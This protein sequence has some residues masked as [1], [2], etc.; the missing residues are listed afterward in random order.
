[1]LSGSAHAPF[2]VSGGCPRS[3]DATRESRLQ[4][5]RDLPKNEKCEPRRRPWQSSFD[6]KTRITSPNLR[7]KSPSPL[8]RLILT[9]V[10]LSGDLI[11]TALRSDQYTM[12]ISM[13]RPPS[14]TNG[15]RPP[16]GAPS[17]DDGANARRPHSASTS[18]K[19]H[20]CCW[21][22]RRLISCA[23]AARSSPWPPPPSP[24]TSR[25]RLRPLL[26]FI[27]GGGLAFRFSVSVRD[28]EFL[29]LHAGALDS[30]FLDEINKESI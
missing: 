9:P 26:S 25:R 1:M 8:W 10:N 5:Q 24:L 28:F 29:V 11:Q 30:F 7:K 2:F 27:G 17:P 6:D 12:H 16:R 21:I 3:D 23:V 4:P 19:P 20:D 22:C 15:N 18:R 13:P 14:R